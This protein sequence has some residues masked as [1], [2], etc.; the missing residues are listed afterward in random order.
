MKTSLLSYGLLFFGIT[1]C[2]AQVSPDCSTA[3]PICSNVPITATVDGYGTDDFPGVSILA[4]DCLESATPNGPIESNSAWYKFRTGASGQLGFNIQ[5][6]NNDDWDFALFKAS[7]CDNLGDPVRCN[8]DVNGGSTGYT[9]IGVNPDTGTQGLGYEDWLT[10]EAG[11]E[12]YLLI[13]NFSGVNSGFSIHFSGQVFVDYPDSA[14]DCTILTNLLGPDV[15]ACDGETV[16]LQ[17][18]LPDATAYTWYEVVNGTENEITAN[19]NN[20]TLSVTSSGTYKV[21]VELNGGGEYIESSTTVTFSTV[22]IAEPLTDE[23]E[24]DLNGNGMAVFD[25]AAKDSEALGSQN[26]SE[27]TVSYH[28]NFYD[29]QIGANPLSK[30]YE[31]T[32]SPYN[33]TIYVRVASVSNPMCYDASQSFTIEVVKQPDVA[34]NTNAYLCQSNAVTIGDTNN[35]SGYLYEW[36][37]GMT[38]PTQVVSTPGTYTL[39]IKNQVGGISCNITKVITVQASQPPV[40]AIIEINDV[41]DNN[42]VTVYTENEGDY[43]YKLGNNP[44]QDSPIFTNVL[45]G[46]YTLT[47]NDKNGCGSVTENILVVGF[48]KFFTPNGDGINDTWHIEGLETLDEATVYIFDRFGKQIKKLSKS[49]NTWD[50][51]YK[52]VLLPSTDYW[53]RI[54]YVKTVNNQLISGVTTKH[55][56]LKR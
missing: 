56:T 7:D 4:D 34:V 50:G 1:L 31:N 20:D 18:T 22:P 49:N 10:V 40:I 54:E 41:Q 21:V 33:Q 55:F 46:A 48:S 35:N 5:Y 43:E 23:F 14:L 9:G 17:A 24:C 11:E 26:S 8:F 6:S 42:T 51:R 27:F 16:T 53:V 47:V 13:N 3:I 12:Y 30:Q 38:T 28:A 52:G 39:T 32:S 15:F 45:P 29:A 19:S 36:D 37:N 25:L 2:T 44:Y